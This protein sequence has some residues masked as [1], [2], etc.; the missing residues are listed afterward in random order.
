MAI[1]TTNFATFFAPLWTA[2]FGISFAIQ[3]PVKEFVSACIF[4]LAQHP[5]DVGDLVILEDEKNLKLVVKEISLM[6][7]TFQPVEGGKQYHVPHTKLSK[8]C[9]ENF[10]RPDSHISV[11][12]QL[13]FKNLPPNIEKFVHN[14]QSGLKVELDKE[15]RKIED[16]ETEASKT[17]A[18]ED[19]E[20]HQILRLYDMPKVTL[21]QFKDE[22]FVEGGIHVEFTVKSQV[23]PLILCRI[24]TE[25]YLHYTDCLDSSDFL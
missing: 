9:I 16:L 22:E 6:H 25:V 20:K 18:F 17:S 4:V 1:F 12:L 21:A 3:D 2:F 13:K 24:R 19:Y 14:I 23:R 11:A 7:T 5:Y 8:E 10:C 15:V